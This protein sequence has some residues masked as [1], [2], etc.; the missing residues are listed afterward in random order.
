MLSINLVQTTPITIEMNYTIGL[1]TLFMNTKSATIGSTIVDHHNLSLIMKN[2]P[3]I[4][5]HGEA[6]RV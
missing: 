2:S 6:T 5:F 1:I 4:H 3:S